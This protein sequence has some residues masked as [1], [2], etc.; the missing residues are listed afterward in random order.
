MMRLKT[1]H[2]LSRFVTVALLIAS[3]LSA[4]IR[5]AHADGYSAHS[6]HRVLS[7]GHNLAHSCD[8]D[9]DGHAHATQDSARVECDVAL[10]AVEAHMHIYLLGFEFTIPVEYPADD[11]TG[12]APDNGVVRLVNQNIDATSR[13]ANVDNAAATFV[14]L[15]VMAPACVAGATAM[16]RLA[17]A[18]PPLCAVARFERTGVLRI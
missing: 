6:H 14:P 7:N 13:A 12:V 11:S 4:G 16:T 2:T 5:D 8:R 10:A 15:I 18:S 9:C 17:V 1:L 3:A